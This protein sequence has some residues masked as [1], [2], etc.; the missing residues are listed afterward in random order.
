M[1]CNTNTCGCTSTAT[2]SATHTSAT[3]TT[4]PQTTR[5]IR[6]DVDILETP[7]AFLIRADV[8]GARPEGI[9]LSV[10]RSVLTLRA[11]VDAPAQQTPVRS[12]VR[13]FRVGEYARSFRLGEGVDTAAISGELALGV[14]TITVPK[15][16]EQRPRTIQIKSN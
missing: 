7:D 16:P 15:S 10:E 4:S 2:D 6:P 1:N 5:T 9:N 12:L 8:P 14:L 3:E 11:A 13:E